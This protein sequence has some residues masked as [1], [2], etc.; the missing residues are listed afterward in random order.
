MST[1]NFT[2]RD[3][4]EGVDSLFTTRWSPRQYLSTP[5][6]DSDLRIIFDA[7]RWSPSSYNEQPWFF[8]TSTA[9]SYD[10]FFNLLFEDN[11]AWAKTAPVIGFVLSKKHFDLNGSENFYGS[12]DAGAAWMAMSLQ[13]KMMNLYTHGLGGIHYDHVYDVFDIDREKYTVICGFTIGYA[14]PEGGE[15]ITDR[16]ELTKTWRSIK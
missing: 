12:F 3:A 14:D 1:Q 6:S 10:T 2:S 8:I 9:S 5:V 15:E 11:Q 13:A 7:A 4:I 16:H